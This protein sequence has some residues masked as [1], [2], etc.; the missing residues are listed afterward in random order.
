MNVKSR[1]NRDGV[2]LL[3]VLSMIVLFLLMGTT[4]VVV[5]NDFAK[6][7][8][9]RSLSSALAS[10]D[11]ENPAEILDDAFY[12][13]VRGPSLDNEDSPLRTHSLLEDQYG[14]G[15][16]GEVASSTNAGI[17]PVVL[18][19]SPPAGQQQ[20]AFDEQLYQIPMRVGSIES[21]RLGTPWFTIDGSGDPELDEYYDRIFIGQVISITS[22]NATGYS[23]RIVQHDYLDTNNDGMLDEDDQIRFLV[24]RESVD[25]TEA[26]PGDEI[27]VNGRDFSGTG[28]GQGIDYTPSGGGAPQAIVGSTEPYWPRRILRELDKDAAPQP[29]LNDSGLFPNLIGQERSNLI[30]F[31]VTHDGSTNEPYDLPDFQNMFLSGPIFNPANGEIIGYVPSFHR[32]SLMINRQ[33]SL[34][35]GATLRDH[36]ASSLTPGITSAPISPDRM[37]QYSFRPICVANPTASPARFPLPGSTANF[38][39]YDNYF[40]KPYRLSQMVQMVQTLTIATS[41]VSLRQIKIRS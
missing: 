21:I 19:P 4:F 27:I 18:F 23:G 29:L 2:T 39:F 36:T 28:A 25:L 30:D 8:R 10:S 9:R 1:N 32:D 7:A 41:P 17:G 14:Y 22:G 12:L 31:F 3:F 34:A 16:K 5:A 37:R 33:E 15:F 11:N 13:L 24:L 26:Q 20:R 6:A 35:A 38:D 40:I